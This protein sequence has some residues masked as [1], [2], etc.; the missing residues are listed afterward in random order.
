[1]AF[2][3]HIRASIWTEEETVASVRR[4][5][6]RD[7]LSPSRMGDF[8]V[9][10]WSPKTEIGRKIEGGAFGIE[11]WVV[12]GKE[13]E[14]LVGNGELW[15]DVEWVGYSCVRNAVP[16]LPSEE[17]RRAKGK[18]MYRDPMEM[19]EVRYG[20]KP[21]AWGKRIAGESQGAV[22]KWGV[23]EK[24]VKRFIAETEKENTGSQGVLKKLGFKRYDL[25]YWEEESAVEWMC[26]VEGNLA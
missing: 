21:E 2:G 15:K 3:G 12:E 19:V 24:G 13:Y 4:G 23:G 17:E 9:G 20:L 6:E 5:V 22:M 14:N 10:L 1:M 26:E 7:W 18:E 8:A 16:A 11:V 25:G